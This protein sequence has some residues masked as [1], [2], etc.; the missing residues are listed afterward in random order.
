MG[1]EL[2][3]ENLNILK[4]P[5]LDVEK[6]SVLIINGE[7]KAFGEN[8]KKQAIE[9]NISITQSGEKLLAPLLVDLHSR[10]E[11]PLNGFEDNLVKL[12]HRAKKSG[13]G[14]VAILPDSE[15]FRDNPEKI[16]IQNNQIN[17]INILFWGSFTQ[18]DAGLSLSPLEELFKLGTIGLTSSIF[19]DLSII[20]KGLKLNN[21]DSYPLLLAINKRDS[22]D[23][24]FV[25][26]DI[27]SLQYGFHGIDTYSTA[28]NIQKIFE[29]QDCFPN[30]KIIIKNISDMKTCNIL[31][32]Y[33]KSIKTS[34]SW[35]NLIADTSNLKLNDMGWK[36]DPPI[37]SAKNRDLLISCME[38]DIIDAIA[39]NSYS[40]NDQETFKPINERPAGISSFELV[41]PL[42]WEELII[43]RSWETSKLWN[44]LSFIPSQLIGIEKESLKIGSNRW[45]IFD[46]KTT[47]VN[48]QIN[49]GYDSPSN[50][51]MKDEEIKGKV[52][53][54]GLEF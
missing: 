7:I 49:L 3:F 16:P 17:D 4:G 46:P 54:C 34:I 22:K 26:E 1:K 53:Q 44:H 11:D 28:N 8:A 40:F 27:K 35:W 39:V 25:Y 9:K 21:I 23:K 36:V 48:S 19:S 2:Y 6:D 24:A 18:K 43:K 33:K 47:W 37:G 52:I 15:K 41:L 20:F 50:F 45:L 30:K 5:D 32:R 51:P 42:L 31:R 29:I 10:L 38:E 13:Y 12:K 14:V